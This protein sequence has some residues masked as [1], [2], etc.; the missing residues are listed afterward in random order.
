MI[1]KYAKH[2]DKSVKKI[3]DKIAIR[4][5]LVLVEKLE[6]AQSLSEISN[7]QAMANNP[8]LFRIRT[9]D[10]RLIV[11]Q[12]DTNTIEILLIEYLKRDDNTYRKYN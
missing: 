7:V 12:T 1:L 9:G 3:K 2:F 6:E 11:E 10:Y 4:R 8:F 5:L